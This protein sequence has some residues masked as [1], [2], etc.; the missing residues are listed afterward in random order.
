MTRAVTDAIQQPIWTVRADGVLVDVN[1][2]WRSSVGVSDD[3]IP[4]RPW[5]EAVHPQDRPRIETAWREAVAGGAA[6]GVECR[7]RLAAG[8]YRWCRARLVPLPEGEGLWVGTAVDIEERHR[9]ERALGESEAR[10]RDV[11]DHANDIIYTIGLDGEI[12]AINRAV[13]QILGYRPEELVGRSVTTIIAPDHIARSHDKLDAKLAGEA[14]SAYELD[15]L[16][17]D[18]RRVPLEINSRLVRVEGRP[19]VIHGIARDVSLRRERSRQLELGAAIGAALAARQPLAGKMQRCAEAIVAHLDVA[20]V[21]IWILAEED[22]ATL[23]LRASVGPAAPRAGEHGRIPVGQGTIG[24]I[25]AECRAHLWHAA[26]GGAEPDDQ[27]WAREEGMAAFVGYPLHIGDR[28]L[29]VLALFARQPL[30][31]AALAMLPSTVDAMALAIDRDQAEHAREA[32]LRRERTARRWAQATEARYRGLFEGVAD[33]ILVLDADRRCQDANAA[34]TALLG[35]EYAELTQLRI[36]DMVVGDPAWMRHEE[37]DPEHK[38]HWQAHLEL[39]RKD[40]STVPVEARATVVDLPEGPVFLAALRDIT[41]R[42]RLEILQRDFLAMVTHDLRSPLTSIKGRA[43]LLLRQVHGDARV[44]RAAG[45][46]LEQVGR[47]EHLINDLA[48]V[49]RLESGEL[50]MHPSEVDLAELAREQLALIGEE[51]ERHTLRLESAGATTGV[52]DRQ[53]LGQVLHNLLT[54]AIKY[55]PDGGDVVVRVRGTGAEVQLSVADQGMGIPEEQ[56]PLL[57]ERFYRADATGAGGL[58]LGLYITKMLVEA[59]GGRIWAVSAPGEGSVFTVALPRRP[60]LRSALGHR[61]PT[62]G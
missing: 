9:A 51:T 45:S 56:L 46:I 55:S 48:D 2:C 26:T 38:G 6:V 61:S 39:R 34:A 47:M 19:A 54:N 12:L 23:V 8:G 60:A 1:A 14:A 17:R 22:P 49:V 44:E 53:R 10:Y 40:G 7:R 5:T 50:R 18:G 58:G 41:E 43:Q 25:A 29:G 33:A 57:F 24:R 3:V 28:V 11:L 30:G 42:A 35:Y 21:R 20:L 62:A 16:H 59:H 52:W 31:E 36:E 4:G 15:G 37:A 32:V 27:A 13:E